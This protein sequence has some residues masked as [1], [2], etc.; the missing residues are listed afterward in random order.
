MNV[1]RVFWFRY[2]TG[3][4]NMGYIVVHERI[5]LNGSSRSGTGDFDWIDLAHD[6]D[7]G[8]LL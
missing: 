1:R 6:R 4:E 5:I 2:L 7:I 3:T 8:G